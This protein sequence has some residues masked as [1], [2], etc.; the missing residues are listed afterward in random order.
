MTVLMQDVVDNGTASGIKL[1]SKVDVA[2]KTGTTTADFDRWFIGY[3]PYYLGGVWTGYD[4]NQSLSDFGHS[5]TIQVE[6]WDIVMSK[7][8]EDIIKKATAGTE[9]LKTF[10]LSEKLVEATICKDSGMLVSDA[11]KLDLQGTN[12]TEKAYF[13]KDTVPTEY[14]TTHVIVPY[15]K[16]SKKVANPNCPETYDVAL[17]NVD[18]NFPKQVVI[19]DT[20]YTCNTKFDPNTM[21]YPT[22]DYYPYYHYALGGGCTGIANEI[23]QKNC[24]C[25][26]HKHK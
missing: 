16:T 19:T 10:E 9:P 2:G 13:T 22:A 18:R 4:L 1:A 7:L 23:A 8:H 14:C 21:K 3:T 25:Q 20:H 5:P 6:I 11:C 17:R 15:C 26:T 24:V 12:R